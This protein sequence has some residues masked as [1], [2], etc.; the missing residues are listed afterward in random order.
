MTAVSVSFALR[1]VPLQG[2]EPAKTAV[3][4]LGAQ[5]IFS[6]TR[7]RDKFDSLQSGPGCLCTAVTPGAS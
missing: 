2:R 6:V 5:R 1:R 3:A 4:Q 7:A